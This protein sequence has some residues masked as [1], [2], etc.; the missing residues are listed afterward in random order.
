MLP[1]HDLKLVVFG[2][3]VHELV[4]KAKK[5]HPKSLAGKSSPT[6]PVYTYKA[7][8]EC[9][10]GTV[11]VF[12]HGSDQIWDPQFRLDSS[13]GSRPDGLIAF[14]AGLTSY[15]EWIPV[16][17]A[18]H[19]ASLPFAATEYAEHSAELQRSDFPKFLGGLSRRESDYRI[20]MNPFQRPGQRS[21]PS[22]RL[23][24]AVNGFT[25]VVWKSG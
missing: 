19:I 22:S 5:S 10:S 7:P 15:A 12:L 23:P 6:T 16:I 1:Y 21:L 18:S 2:Q 8:E 4:R 25:I 14:N 13:Y 17:R 3:S 20:E 24:N 11:E 9:G